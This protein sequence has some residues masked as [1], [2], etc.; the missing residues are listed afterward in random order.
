MIEARLA[1]QVGGLFFAKKLA[2]M[3]ATV[4]VMR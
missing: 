2:K 4:N 3:F 1:L